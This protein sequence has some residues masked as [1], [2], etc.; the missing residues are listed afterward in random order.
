[1]LNNLWEEVFTL[2]VDDYNFSDYHTCGSNTPLC[3]IFSQFY[4]LSQILERC[5]LGSEEKRTFGS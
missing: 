2:L 4:L 5:R 3:K 1:M